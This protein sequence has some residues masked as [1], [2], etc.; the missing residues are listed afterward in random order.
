MLAAGGARGLTLRELGE[1]EGR[2]HFTCVDVASPAELVVGVVCSWGV[3]LDAEE[4]TET[5]FL[6]THSRLSSEPDRLHR[7]L[8]FDHGSR[9]VSSFS[10]FIAQGEH[11]PASGAGFLIL[12]GPTV[13]WSQGDLIRYV[14]GRSSEPVTLS[15]G[16]GGGSAVVERLWGFNW[17][18]GTSSDD[19]G[20]VLLL[21]RS[22]VREGAGPGSREEA[23]P[24]SKEGAGP[25][26]RGAMQWS[27]WQ[28]GFT[29]RGVAVKQLPPS[30]CI[31]P[32]YGIL[33]T[34]I[35]MTTLLGNSGCG[36]VTR[37]PLFLVGTS[38]RQVAVFVGGAL[39]YCIPLP[40]ALQSVVGLG[41][42][43]APSLGPRPPQHSGC[44]GRVCSVCL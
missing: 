23:G 41:V 36:S 8:S 37:K 33:A 7:L 16:C 12:D 4:G 17:S 18:H 35:S 38:Y 44:G 21:V 2:W 15:L 39:L 14:R 1:R 5:A 40:F 24:D 13:L 31:P 27:C 32:E 11:P 19:A 28:L 29:E 9:E 22:H 6:L 10:K 42:S 30:S 20:R 25:G 43:G 34:S 3:A 26:G